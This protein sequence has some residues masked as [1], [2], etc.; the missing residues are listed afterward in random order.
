MIQVNARASAMTERRVARLDAADSP[1]QPAC[2]DVRLRR[3]DLLEPGY[4]R[5]DEVIADL[6]EVVQPIVELPAMRRRRVEQRL[7]R[8]VRHRADEVECRRARPLEGGESTLAF[9]HLPTP[10]DADDRHAP[11]LQLAREG[12]LRRGGEHDV[13]DRQLLGS[14]RHEVATRLEY[15]TRLFPRVH[16]APGQHDRADAVGTKLE[17]GDDAEVAAAAAKRPEQIRV[18]VGARTH[19]RA[20]GEHDLGG[21][22]RVDRSSPWWRMSQPIPPPS[23]SPPTPVWETWPAGTARPCAWVAASSSARSVPPPTR[24]IRRSGSTWTELKRADVDADCAVAHRPAGDGM[25]TGADRERRPRRASGTDRRSD[26]VGIRRKGDGR[27]RAVDGAV[28]S[29]ASRV[30]VG[31]S[32][33]DDAAD[34]A[35]AAHRRGER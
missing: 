7:Q 2:D 21:Q 9:G 29:H 20:V 4:Q 31:V 28:P 3:R 24:T 12:G 1:A 19:R 30:V 22:Q 17:R 14:V 34:E 25:A 15:R 35:A 8:D 18:L 33:L 13:D 5:V 10:G 23:V 16:E 27:R 26:I 32:R 11:T 6:V